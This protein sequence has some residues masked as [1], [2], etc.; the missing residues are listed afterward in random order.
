MI[1]SD[2]ESEI[3]DLLRCGAQI[4]KEI[5]YLNRKVKILILSS[6]TRSP[7]WG[8]SYYVE[9]SSVDYESKYCFYQGFYTTDERGKDIPGCDEII[10]SEIKEIFNLLYGFPSTSSYAKEINDCLEVSTPEFLEERRRKYHHEYNICCKCTRHDKKDLSL[11]SLTIYPFICLYCSDPSKALMKT[12]EE[13][14]KILFMPGLSSIL[15]GK[16]ELPS[17]WQI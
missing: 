6:Y 17:D 12:I 14:S 15:Y 1:N 9:I 3:K 7:R 10:F 11:D 8:E 16:P 13:T 2:L 4:E 5:E